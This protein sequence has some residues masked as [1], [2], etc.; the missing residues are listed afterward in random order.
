VLHTQSGEAFQTDRPIEYEE[1][2]KSFTATELVA[3]GFGVCLATTLEPLFERLGVDI[4]K[5]TIFNARQLIQDHP[6]KI[7]RIASEIHLP[8][9]IDDDAQR[10]IMRAAATCPV[11]RSL[12]PDIAVDIRIVAGINK[13]AGSIE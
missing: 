5:V 4:S 13:P 2:G 6:R 3:A 8:V 10:R 11:A 1:Q 7:L 12:H 9:P